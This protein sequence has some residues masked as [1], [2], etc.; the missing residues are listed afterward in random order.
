PDWLAAGYRVLLDRDRIAD[1]LPPPSVLAYVPRPP[2]D[3]EY[4]AVVEEFWW[5]SLYVA[6]YIGRGELLP[7]RYSLETVLRYRCLVPM[8]EWYVQIGRGWEQSVGVRGSGLRWLLA[9]DERTAL[10]ATYAGDT[11]RGHAEALEAMVELFTH[12]ARAI[13]RDLGYT[14]PSTVDRETRMLLR[15]D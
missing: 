12:A 10:D 1:R 2:S 4:R 15:R 11:L 9:P 13:A 14:Y 8:L 5:E 3:A 6:K 7:A